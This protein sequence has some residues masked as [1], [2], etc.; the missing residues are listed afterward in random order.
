MF[1]SDATTHRP[2]NVLGFLLPNHPDRLHETE[3]SFGK[4]WLFYPEATK[5]R[6]ESAL[7]LDVDP[8]GLV[9]GKV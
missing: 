3:L 6:C 1:L 8:V 2:A 9:R 7:N 5:D 4:A